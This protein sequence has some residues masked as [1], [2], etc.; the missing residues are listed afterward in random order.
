MW[1]QRQLRK[2][3]EQAAALRPVILLTGAR[4]TGKS[5]LLQRTFPDIPAVNLDRPAAAQAAI[6]APEQF[7]DD[8]GTPLMLDEVQYA[9]GLFREIKPRVDARRMAGV[10]YLLTGSQRFELM[11][12]VSESL[13]GRIR[14]LELGTLSAAE[15]RA[16]ELDV[17]AYRWRGGY[18]EL[19]AQ[20]KLSQREYFEDYVATYLE[21]DL[22]QVI[23]V[24]SL[25]DFRRFIVAC[26]TRVGQLINFS[27]LARDVGIAAN[28]ARNWLHALDA[29]GLIHVLPPYFANI[30]KRL[31]KAPKLYFADHGLLCHLLSIH[32]EAA[33]RQH[34]HAGAV[35]ENLVLAELVKTRQ[36]KPGRNL[37]FYRDQNAVEIDFVIETDAALELIE[38]KAAERPDRR[39]LNFRKVAPIFADRAITCTLACQTPEPKPLTMADYRMLNPLR[40]PI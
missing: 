31:T 8:H 12:G 29:T 18:P 19:W 25:I 10:Q 36:L 17:D 11:G 28:T 21:R 22:H 13:A 14:I 24:A 40:H 16:A 34:P 15:L 9:P 33:L 2:N 30:G 32:D 7:L 23:H 1:V 39:K 4:Q 26:A 27:D 5:S 3:L 38:A 6:D 37:F 35:W 20:P